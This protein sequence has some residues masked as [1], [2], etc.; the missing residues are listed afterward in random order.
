MRRSRTRVRNARKACWAAKDS[1]LEK[2]FGSCHVNR[3][4]P[5]ACSFRSMSSTWTGNDEFEKYGG[6]FLP[7]VPRSA[8]Q[9]IPCLSY[10]EAP[11]ESKTRITEISSSFIPSHRV[12]IVSQSRIPLLCDV[13]RSKSSHRNCILL[14][15]FWII[16]FSTS[17]SFLMNYNALR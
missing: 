5:S 6:I 2:G 7:G 3:F 16:R 14:F 12:E 13:Y 11:S 1:V 17:Y 8:L 9:P 15:T 4:T 10:P